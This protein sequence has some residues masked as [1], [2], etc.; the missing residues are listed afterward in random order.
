MDADEHRPELFA[1]LPVRAYAA[2]AKD[3]FDTR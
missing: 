1:D 3:P 2:I